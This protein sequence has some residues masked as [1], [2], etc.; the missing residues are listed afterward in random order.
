MRE[1]P[2]N[3]TPILLLY[4]NG[5]DKAINVVLRRDVALDE[6]LSGKIKEGT[7]FDLITPYGYG[8]FWG[9]IS[10]WNKLNQTYAE[11]CKKIVIYVNL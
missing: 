3:G 7:Y 10:D 1:A 5:K 11:Y 6:K 9:S 2:K 4:E 8:G